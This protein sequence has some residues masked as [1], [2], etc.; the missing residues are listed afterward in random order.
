M[1]SAIARSSRHFSKLAV[2]S[3]Y[4]Q[5]PLPYAL[6]ALEPYISQTIMDLHYNKHHKTYV[7]N[8][9]KAADELQAATEAEDIASQVRL[10]QAVKFNGGGNLN[11]ELFWNNMAPA[12]SGGGSPPAAGSV[13]DTAINA[14]FG[15]F[16][17]FQ[18]VFKTKALGVQGSGWAWL[19]YDPAVKAVVVA[20][21]ANQDPLE[22][23][24]GLKPLVGVDVWEHA[25]YLDYENRRPEY[26]DNIWNVINWAEAEKRFEACQ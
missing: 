2:R 20:T 1:L 3:K 19:A 13:L 9:N 24:T 4:T 18:A 15:S 14:T 22:S 16:D 26:I 11:H 21:T 25:Y 7:D 17:N 8:L 5:A 6:D 12:S 23:T 10:H